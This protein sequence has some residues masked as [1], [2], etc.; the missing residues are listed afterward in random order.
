MA[1]R[2]TPLPPEWRSTIRPAIL[3]RDGYRCTWFPGGQADGSDYSKSYEHPYRCQRRATDV[4]HVGSNEDHSLDKLRALCSHHH[5]Q[6]TS[7]FSNRR[8]RN[9][10]HVRMFRGHRGRKHPGLSGQ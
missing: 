10:E 2:T 6:K 4:D 7:T 8:S 1:W 5:R 9:N 3:E